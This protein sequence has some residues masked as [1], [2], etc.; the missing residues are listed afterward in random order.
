ME[1]AIASSSDPTVDATL[2]WSLVKAVG[3]EADR[4]VA[5]RRRRRAAEAEEASAAGMRFATIFRA[6]ARRAIEADGGGP[7]VL[8][9][10]STV[11]AELARLIGRSD[12]DAWATVV[13]ARAAVDQPWELAYARLRH[14]EA[15]LA[16]GGPAG[17]AAAALRLAHE[18]ATSL[19][20][21]A[22]RSEIEAVAGRARIQLP[23]GQGRDAGQPPGP[24]GPR[25]TAREVSVIALVA[26]GHTNREIGDRLF[27]SEK[28]V[29]VHVT[30]AM[31]KLGALSR[32][33][34]AASAER[35]GLLDVARTA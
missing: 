22:L 31:E 1:A 32:Y 16:Q 15:I 27:I 4:A 23:P 21:M 18:A 20:A 26:A 19:D 3:G 17:S 28:T 7:A 12:A 10:R 24:A 13:A 9:W 5:A 34:A 30:H 11:E 35:L 33:E 14:G 29:S 25:L 2:W 8:A 6:S